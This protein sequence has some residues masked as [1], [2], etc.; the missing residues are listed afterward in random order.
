MSHIA[1]PID[2]GTVSFFV[3][4]GMATNAATKR[5]ASA[6]KRMVM[7]WIAAEAEIIPSPYRTFVLM[8][9]AHSAEYHPALGW[10]SYSFKSNASPLSST[11]RFT[12]FSNSLNFADGSA[13]L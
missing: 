7:A 5:T 8:I 12:R 9:L 2:P 10:E 1:H 11:N 4:I 3:A 6:A 13:A